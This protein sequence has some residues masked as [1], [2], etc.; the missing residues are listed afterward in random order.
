MTDAEREAFRA[1][2]RAYLLEHPEVIVEAIQILESRREAEEGKAD[3][4]LIAENRDAIFND[5][6][7]WVGGNPDGDVTLVEF[8][9]YRCGYCKRAHPEV[10]ALI[11]QD[12]EIRYVAKEFPILGP[13]SVAASRMALAALDMDSSKYGELHD[14]L[15]S[16][17]GQLTEAAA[18]QIARSVG[19]DTEALEERAG[20][21]GIEA[22]IRENYRLAQALGINGTPGFVLEDRIIRGYLPLEDMASEVAEVRSAMN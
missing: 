20:S 22:R 17:E 1:E 2:V 9:D 14:A 11:E 10:Q 19:Y 8:F 13:A 4:E 3:A 18:Y 16:F 15:M 21:D 5:P 12:P 6:D 7:D